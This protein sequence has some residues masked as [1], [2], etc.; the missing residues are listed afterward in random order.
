MT[1]NLSLSIRLIFLLAS[2]SLW[3]GL[4]AA[5]NRHTI[6]DTSKGADGVRLE[7]VNGDGLMDVA[8]GWEEGG[9]VRIYLNP[10]KDK[11]HSPW[12]SVT[13]GHVKSPEDAVF[14]DMDSD[15]IMD[16]VSACE[17][18][19]KSVFVHWAPKNKHDYLN[20]SKW[21][22]EAIPSLQKKSMWMFCKPARID[23]NRSIDLIVGSKGEKASVGW[24]EAPP[25]GRVLED[26][27]W[28][29]IYEAGWIMSIMT[30]DADHDG[31]QDILISDRRKSK[32]GVVL[33]ENPHANVQGEQPLTWKEHR[34]G[35]TGNEVL[36][37]DYSQP[38]QEPNMTVWAAV[39][40]NVIW[41]LE[42][43]DPFSETWKQ[44]IVQMPD[45]M[46]RSKAVRHGDLNMD[47][48]T[49]LVVNCEGAGGGK[50][51]MAW[52]TPTSSI[53]GT[54]PKRI[55]HDIAGP[56]GIKFDRIELLD[57]DMDGDLDVLTCEERENLGV[58]WYEN[59]HIK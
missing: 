45:W 27:Q 6:D 32:S 18:K 57:L 19:T 25:E 37:I 39:K 4:N 48:H 43:A 14:A 17:G 5:W 42:S 26:W 40:P 7:D 50:S 8:T 28:H 33:L 13:V 44:E 49:D 1:H 22:T 20:A 59:P 36:F 34:V 52:F 16:I 55:F 51:G 31:D 30:F 24:L 11:V 56:Q 35:P 2:L 12:P 10:G 21:E 54:K 23:N 38:T 41:Q 46:S 29:P 47:G 3:H 58:V 9:L 53:N 15:G